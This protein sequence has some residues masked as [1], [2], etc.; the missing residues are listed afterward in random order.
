MFVAITTVPVAAGSI[1]SLA[2]LFD[3]TNRELV[4]GHEEWL[5][6]WFTADREAS[7][8]TVIAR[9]ASAAAYERLRDS[10]EYRAAL[11]PFAESF[12]GP[13]VI[14]VKEILVEM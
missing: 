1:D 14:S 8:V 13:P 5:G 11:A 12:T 9:W 3:A 6:A 4:A 7:E 10:D 2:E